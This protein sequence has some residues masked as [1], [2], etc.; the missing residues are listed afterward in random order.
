MAGV[1][2]R[3]V[4]EL[5]GHWDPKMTMRYAH[6]SPAH[7]AAAVARLADALTAP[8][9]TCGVDASATNSNHRGDSPAD[10]AA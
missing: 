4:G 2:L 5:L 8:T 3:S 6:F 1:D 10:I 7:K 9:L